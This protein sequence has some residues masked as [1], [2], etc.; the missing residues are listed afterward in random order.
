M[1]ILKFSCITIWYLLVD[2]GNLM[3]SEDLFDI[4]HDGP[5]KFIGT[6]HAH[7]LFLRKIDNILVSVSPAICSQWENGTSTVS[8]VNNSGFNIISLNERV[9]IE[10]HFI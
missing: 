2:V 5:V 1:R 10:T 4:C 6:G 3:N 9:F 7:T 8:I